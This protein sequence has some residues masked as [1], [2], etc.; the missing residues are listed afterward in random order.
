MTA[1]ERGITKSKTA[2]RKYSAQRL[3]IRYGELLRL[4]RAVRQ[5]ELQAGRAK[6]G[7]NLQ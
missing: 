2:N 5:A 7:I 3:T 1:K 4:R 6:V